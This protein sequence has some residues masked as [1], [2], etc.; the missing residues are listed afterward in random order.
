MIGVGPWSRAVTA[1][2]PP[3]PPR[4]SLVV[5][6]VGAATYA[7][8]VAAVAQVLRFEEQHATGGT[9][10]WPARTVQFEGSAIPAIDLR[11]LSGS[12]P[13]KRGVYVRTIVLRAGKE[14]FGVTVDEVHEVTSVPESVLE[15]PDSESA[16]GAQG[17]GA[18]DAP[19]FP[20]GG[21]AVV[22]ARVRIGDRVVA[23]LDPA[24]II[25]A[26]AIAVADGAREHHGNG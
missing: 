6:R 11:R 23:V 19:G 4:V 16:T 2:R 8:D 1:P 17:A 9:P 21:A 5:F 10:P 12:A 20:C 26:A 14:T 15:S 3:A 7:V 24:L 13:P 25:Q 22:S 18:E